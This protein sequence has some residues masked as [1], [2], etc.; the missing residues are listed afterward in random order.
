MLQ[1]LEQFGA[2]DVTERREPQQLLALP[3]SHCGPSRARVDASESTMWNRD[4]C[5]LLQLATDGIDD[6]MYALARRLRP[7][8]FIGVRAT[9]LKQAVEQLGPDVTK[10]DGYYCLSA[11]TL[12]YRQADIAAAS[13]LE[14]S[15]MEEVRC[16]IDLGVSAEGVREAEEKSLEDTARR[17]LGE[18][19][20]LCLGD[21]LWS[22]DLQ[23]KLRQRLGVDVPLKFWHGP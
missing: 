8:I 17:A 14:R 16:Q 7:D 18:A 3:C 13:G 15:W 1:I 10:L 19:C 5:P 12:P 22:E 9:H 20:G 11:V 6:T 4:D 2:P 21:G 23:L